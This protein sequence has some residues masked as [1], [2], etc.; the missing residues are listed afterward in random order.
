MKTTDS[1][2]PPLSQTMYGEAQATGEASGKAPQIKTDARQRNTREASAAPPRRLRFPPP[3]PPPPRTNAVNQNDSGVTRVRLQGIG[4]KTSYTLKEVLRMTG[5][6]F[7]KPFTSFLTY[8][9]NAGS[10]LIDGKPATQS[11]KD[12]IERITSKFDAVVGLASRSGQMQL[13]GKILHRI[14]DAAHGKPFSREDMASDLLDGVSSVDVKLPDFKGEMPGRLGS[15]SLQSS[16]AEASGS[17]PAASEVGKESV[18]LL[19]QL[20]R[21]GPPDLVPAANRQAD[22]QRID[23]FCGPVSFY[24]K[25]REAPAPDFPSV[26]HATEYKD[27]RNVLTVGKGK[28]LTFYDAEEKAG[29]NGDKAADMTPELA[30]ASVI[31]L[32]SGKD[33]VAAVN[34]CFEDLAPGST[35]IVSSGPMRGSTMLFT[36]D[37]TGF[38]AYHA[39]A[40]KQTRAKAADA[41]ASS[42]AEAHERFG[43]THADATPQQ[44]GMDALYRAA[45]SHPFSAI[46]SSYGDPPAGQPHPKYAPSNDAGLGADGR[47]WS[48][49]NFNYVGADQSPR[50]VGSAEAII[51]KDENGKI[52]VQ[53]LAERG[54]LGYKPTRGWSTSPTASFNYRQLESAVGRYS[55]DHA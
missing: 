25:D 53:V 41:E 13:A 23:A 16:S 40:S 27:R 19:K 20:V 5:D 42:I 3:P 2:M 14:N 45:T 49:M 29:V 39:G 55:V 47:P 22:Q 4:I 54:K 43:S 33:G 34:V 35:T 46:V 1:A 31:Q 17:E 10:L 38:S 24:R 32:G 6:A 26:I 18:S 52:T 51:R 30:N 15:P 7:E 44:N 50:E 37:E 11:Q 36:A 8:M 48:M 21:R 12:A 28:D 9:S